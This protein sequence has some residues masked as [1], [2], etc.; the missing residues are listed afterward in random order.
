MC[1]DLGKRERAGVVV[2]EELQQDPARRSNTLAVM[3]QNG[4][5]VFVFPHGMRL[6]EVVYWLGVVQP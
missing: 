3:A 6:P 1:L 4:K 2:D 5:Q